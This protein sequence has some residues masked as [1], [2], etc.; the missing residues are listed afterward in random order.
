MTKRVL[1]IGAHADDETLGCGG[2]LLKHRAQGD[3]VHWLIATAM[4][5]PMFD[6]ARIARRES[7]IDAVSRAFGMTK[8]NCLKLPTARLDST[9]LAEVIEP[10]RESIA[11]SRPDIV[12][13]VHHGDVHGD[14]RVTF[15]AAVAALKP[16]RSERVSA[17]YGYEC[18]SSTNL[19][20]P[21]NAP[22]VPQAYSDI[23][24]FIERKLDILALYENEIFDAPHP[25]SLDAV[26]ALARYRGTSVSVDYAEA[27]TVVR[28]VW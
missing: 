2:T 25:R 20:P 12:Y 26:R 10:M 6:S 18:A 7:E 9:S 16:F 4:W 8:V 15:D 27:F 11:A 13:L 24:A 3:E 17:I 21:T 14:H 5:E 19:A 22:F 28:E 1:V 23:T